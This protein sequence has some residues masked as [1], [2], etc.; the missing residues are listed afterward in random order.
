MSIHFFCFL[1]ANSYPPPATS[2]SRRRHAARRRKAS[3]QQSLARPSTLDARPDSYRHKKLNI[4]TLL[5]TSYQ[6]PTTSMS[7]RSRAARR[8]EGL[9]AAKSCSP[10]DS[11]RSARFL[12]P[13]KAQHLHA[14]HYKLPVT[15]YFH[16]PPESRSAQADSPFSIAKNHFLYKHQLFVE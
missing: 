12:S 8:P 6:L 2:I 10:L 7:R 9:F 3:S 5:I 4:Y 13:Q 15:R 11:G 14:T 1:L 16:V